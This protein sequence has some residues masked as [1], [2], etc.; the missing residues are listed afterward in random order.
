MSIERWYYKLSNSTQPIM[1]SINDLIKK[2]VKNKKI[3]S[4]AVPSKPPTQQFYPD[5]I[6]DYP[7]VESH[8]IYTF[9]NNDNEDICGTMEASYVAKAM[10]NPKNGYILCAVSDDYETMDTPIIKNILIFNFNE[11]HK[12]PHIEALCTNQTPDVYGAPQYSGGTILLNY[13]INACRQAGAK[14]VTL[15]SLPESEPLYKIYKFKEIGIEDDLKQMARDISPEEKS[16]PSAKSHA[17]HNEIEKVVKSVEKIK[18]DDS[19][20]EKNSPII[21]QI[22]EHNN[23]LATEK[24]KSPSPTEKKKSPSVKTHTEIQKSVIKK[25]KLDDSNIEQNLPVIDQIVEHNKQLAT[26]KKKKK[27]RITKRKRSHTQSVPL[28]RRSKRIQ[29]RNSGIKISQD[30]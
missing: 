12:Y 11:K 27:S 30:I 15:E 7:G 26:E 13:F 28:L 21:D 10:R 8:I 17:T 29:S 20:I 18:L 6:E 22:I 16:P 23:Q 2:E 1:L 25:I 3:N 4:I 14:K 5:P 9:R 19:N 24:K